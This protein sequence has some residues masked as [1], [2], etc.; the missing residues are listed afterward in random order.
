[1]II[2]YRI[3]YNYREYV[4]ESK[5]AKILRFLYIKLRI[6][7][8][9]A[10]KFTQI[11]FDTDIS[12]IDF[13]ISGNPMTNFYIANF[14]LLQIVKYYIRIQKAVCYRWTTSFKENRKQHVFFLDFDG[15][16]LQ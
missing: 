13:L 5:N 9:F 1:M 2:S 10:P 15:W 4:F 16:P 6:K 8:K 12:F 11:R 14:Y 3:F 7:E